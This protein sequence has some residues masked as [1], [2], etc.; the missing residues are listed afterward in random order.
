MRSIGKLDFN[1]W[2]GDHGLEVCDREW[3]RYANGG[4]FNFTLKLPGEPY[5]AVAL[6]RSC[7]LVHDE[8]SFHGAMVWFRDWGI[9]DNV[10]EE[11]FEQ[12]LRRLRADLGERRSL[13]D[14]P[15]HIFSS[16]EYVDARVMWTQPVLIGWDAILVPEK[17][18]YFVFNSHDEVISFVSRTSE[19]HTRLVEEFKDW[20]PEEDN[21]YFH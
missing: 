21:W 12:T 16:D 15:G 8:D 7:F 5:R 14:V 2:C 1:A 11:T 19:T 9:W 20:G 13:R 17:R 10:D 4:R 3:P 18:D 6:A